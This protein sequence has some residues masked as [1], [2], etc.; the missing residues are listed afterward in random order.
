[1]TTIITGEKIQALSVGDQIL[2]TNLGIDWQAAGLALVLRVKLGS[3][4]SRDLTLL[5]V[6]AQP[7]QAFHSTTATSF[8][9]AGI[10]NAQIIG[11]NGS[12]EEKYSSVFQIDVRKNI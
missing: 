8:P 9:T 1:M 10:Y 5:P 4:A 7:Q 11:K 2:C 3:T 6:P 12:L